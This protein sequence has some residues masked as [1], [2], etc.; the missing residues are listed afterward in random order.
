MYIGINGWTIK[1]GVILFVILN[2]KYEL[3]EE[4][5]RWTDGD[6]NYSILAMSVSRFY[7]ADFELQFEGNLGDSVTVDSYGT[8]VPFRLK[9]I[10][11]DDVPPFRVSDFN[12]DGD[13]DRDEMISIRPYG[14]VADGP[15]ISIR[16]GQD[17]LFISDTTIYD[18][19]YTGSDT[20]Y[21]ARFMI[22]QI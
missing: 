4:S 9:N 5:T 10:T 3:N 20:V 15:L 6:C 11:H 18:T 22:P 8:I 21:T 7:P 2:N 13:W 16:F 19:I 17:S 1:L 12:Q 14:A